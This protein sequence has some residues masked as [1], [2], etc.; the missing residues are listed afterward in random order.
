MELYERITEKIDAESISMHVPGHKNNTI[1]HL[2]NLD[3]S[4]DMTEIEGLDDLHD[5]GEVLSRLNV[6]IAE[7][8]E[9]YKAQL[10][11]N[12]T[13]NGIISAI[14]ALSRTHHHFIVVRDAH[15]SVYHALDLA[16]STFQEIDRSVVC[17]TEFHPGEVVIITYPTYNGE[18]FDIEGM[19]HHIHSY[20]GLVL[21]DEAHGAHLDIAESFPSS[22]MKFAS[23][24]AIQSYHKMLPALTMSSV[25][26]VRDE[27]LYERIMK[28]INYFETSSP[29]YL[30]LLSM[31]QAHEFYMNYSSGE[32]FRKR[33][34]L[35]EAME[36]KGVEVKEQDDPA[37]LLLNYNGMN[38]FMLHAS[39]TDLH[40]YP[41]MVTDEGVLFCLPLFHRG[42]SYPFSLLIERIQEMEFKERGLEPVD[43]QVDI[44]KGRICVKSIVPYPPGVPLVRENEVITGSH[45]KSIKHYLHNHVRIEGIKYNLQ[46]YNNEGDQ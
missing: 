32:F 34:T 36:S 5:P 13:T 38:P 18:C 22:S 20:G 12:G 41:E 25:I 21:I 9:G 45:L 10:M 19:I 7:K 42:D 40:I 6:N 3:W 39:F 15:K 16:G 2:S 43:G 46:Y 17:M 44:L 8:Y 4:Y 26:F 31:E 33:K 37:K 11:V 29:S 23:D 35:I 14:Y 28:Y 1:G 24:I 27:A 30:L